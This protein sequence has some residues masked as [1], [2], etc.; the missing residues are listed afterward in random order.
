M[1]QEVYLIDLKRPWRPIKV[2]KA[3]IASGPKMT[4]AIFSEAAGYGRGQMRYGKRTLLGKGA[5]FTRVDAEAGKVGRLRRA[6][7][8]LEKVMRLPWHIAPNAGESLAKVNAQIAEYENT[9]SVH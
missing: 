7:K 9:G 6:K 3:Q 4:W 5:F 2:A 8:E 1:I